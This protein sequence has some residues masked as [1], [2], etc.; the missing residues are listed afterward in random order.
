[1]KY[2]KSKA[3]DSVDDMAVEVGHLRESKRNDVM[4]RSYL[5]LHFFCLNFPHSLE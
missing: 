1:M 3:E 2:P 5:I 4:V